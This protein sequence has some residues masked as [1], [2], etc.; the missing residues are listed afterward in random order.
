LEDLGVDASLNNSLPIVRWN[1]EWIC[2]KGSVCYERDVVTANGNNLYASCI[3]Q[4]GLTVILIRI[5]LMFNFMSVS[6]MFCKIIYLNSVLILIRVLGYCPFMRSRY[7]SHC[8]QST[9]TKIKIVPNYDR[10]KIFRDN[11]VSCSDKQ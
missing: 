7:R 5:P 4:H 3:A 11:F 2:F 9:Y 1:N 10:R 8:K 6:D